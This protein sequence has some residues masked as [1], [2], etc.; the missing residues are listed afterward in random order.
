MVRKPPESWSTIVKAIGY[1]GRPVRLLIF[2]I[3]MNTNNDGWRW[4]MDVNGWQYVADDQ[5][6]PSADAAAMI[7]VQ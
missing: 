1:T 7:D 4:L 6:E 2:D 3:K 5:Q